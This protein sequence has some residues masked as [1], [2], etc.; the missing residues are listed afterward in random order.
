MDG[1]PQS[2]LAR[3]EFVIR[4]LHS[5]SG[6][7]PVGAYMTVHLVTNASVLNGPGTFQKNVYAIHSLGKLLPLVEWTFIFIPILFH[8]IVG[9]MIAVGHDPQHPRLPLRR[10]PPLHLA[11]LDRPDRVRVHRLPRVPHAR[12]VPLRLVAA[13]DVAGPF[14]GAKFK[15]YNA[16][17]TAGQALQSPGML[18]FYA[19]GVLACVF[20]FANGLWTMGI[21]WG[22]WISP[23]AQTPRA[24]GLHDLRRAAGRRRASAHSTACTNPATA[25]ASKKPS[26]S[27]T[28]CT[29]HKVE[30]G[31]IEP[32]EHKRAVTNGNDARPNRP[33]QTECLSQRR[34]V[35]ETKQRFSVAA[36][37]L[38]RVSAS[39]REF[40]LKAR[41]SR[42]KA[43][44][45]GGW[46]RARGPGRLDEARR[47]GHHRRSDE[48]HARQALAQRLRPGRHQ[49]A[50]T[51]SP[52]SRAT[53]S[54]S[55]STTPSTAATSCSTSR[56]SRRWSTRAP[57]IIDLMDRL[58]VPFNRTPEGF[59]DQRR[60][61]GTLF[62][63]TAFAGA[64]TGQQLLYALDEQVRRWH[65][66]RPGHHVRR[67]GTSWARSS[68]T[69]A[70]AA[71]RVA[72][73]LVT[74]EIR[75]FPADAV[76]IA[77]GG[78]GLIYGR[79]TMRMA[80]N[81][82]AVSRCV[83]GRRQVRQRRV[84]PGPPHR[85]PRRR[86]AAPDERVGPRRRRPRLGPAHAA[87]PAPA[88]AAF[89]RP[90]ATTSSKNAIRSTATSCRATSPPARS[91]TSASTK[92]S[93]SSSD[94]PCVYLDLTHIPRDRAR[95][96]ARRHPGASTRSSRASTRATSR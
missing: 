38:L 74:M 16:A 2:F 68:T 96:Q 61:G 82:S 54:G 94:R 89:P 72:Q 30:T 77:S 34:R 49:L 1:P 25:P 5:L 85:D 55:T 69:P 80:C 76:V 20:H 9:I 52:A 47:A 60:F 13:N 12:L 43:A 24:Q 33:Q 4:R 58:G 83:P 35:A 17:S 29:K 53:A 14:G 88:Q 3:H 71:A 15:P 42:G 45:T 10:Q 18:I 41:K 90:S 67:S 93:A 51:T 37:C 44:C 78:C 23:A 62:K 75:A 63:R 59:R 39:L 11:A 91:S 73:N 8:A 26:K 36:A 40:S 64:T 86:Q 50:S 57:K 56:P 21:T 92:A 48:P 66:E 70:A 19:V 32:N 65:V 84:H 46:R 87:R 81:G 28:A 27:K 6:L 22:V 79:S 31:E 7:I 95:P